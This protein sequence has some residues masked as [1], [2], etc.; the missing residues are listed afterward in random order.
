MTVQEL[1]DKSLQTLG[2]IAP[3]ET[4]APEERTDA[5]SAL[6]SLIANWNA[7]QLPLFSV[8]LTTVPLTGAGSYT[9]GTRPMRI[10]SAQVLAANGAAQAPVLVDAV[11]WASIADKTRTGIYAEALYCDYGFP[12]ATVSLSPRP[13]GGTLEIYSYKQLTEFA[14]LAESIVLPPGYERA[15]RF[16][17]AMDL[18]SEYGRTVTPE[19]AAAA[20][21]A[22]NAIAGLNAVVLGEMAPGPT[23]AT[24]QA[25]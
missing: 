24:K 18:A 21:E 20:Q 13:A 23:A 8:Q 4:P 3:G 19:I 6:N 2:V 14:S 17:L 12:A 25:A 15:L 7:Q 5:L 16:A 9:L 11:G 1:I 22:K 10:K